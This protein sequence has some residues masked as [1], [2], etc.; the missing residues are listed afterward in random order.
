MSLVL[1][2]QKKGRVKR[3]A[4]SATSTLPLAASAYGP[5]VKVH[6]FSAVKALPD[7]SVATVVMRAV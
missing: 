1:M 3:P 5:V 7:K 6:T 2:A 4:P